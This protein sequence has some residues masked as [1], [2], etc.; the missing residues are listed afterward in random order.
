M[1]VRG[2]IAAGGEATRLGE[3][4]RV[5]NKHLLPVGRWPM[6]YY[7]LQLLQ[8]AGVR[9]VLLVTGKGHAGQMIDLLGDGPL[10][11]RGGGD[12]ILALERHE[13]DRG[14]FTELRRDSALPKPTVQTNLSFSRAGVIR[15]L[16]FHERGQDDLFACLRG[17]ARVVVL[18]TESGATYSEDI[19]DENPVALYI[20]GRHAHGFEALTDVLFCYHVTEEYD[21]ADP[22]EHEIAWDDL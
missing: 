11:P 12:P 5:A 1:Q 10:A 20:P 15:G 13:D 9:D 7:P 22:D 17:T 19:G 8:Q 4:T 3:L 2:L 18:D 21:A 14:W 16:H 6:I